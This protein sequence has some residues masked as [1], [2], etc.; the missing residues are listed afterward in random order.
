MGSASAKLRRWSVEL[1]SLRRCWSQISPTLKVV[2]DSSWKVIKMCANA[3][4]YTQRIIL[5]E[6]CFSDCMKLRQWMFDGGPLDSFKR[7]PKVCYNRWGIHV[8]TKHI[9]TL[10]PKHSICFILEKVRYLPYIGLMKWGEVK[11]SDISIKNG[12]RERIESQRLINLYSQKN[13]VTF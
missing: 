8:P 6:V 11:V 7:C 3:T 10:A 9:L 13:N 5:A 1:T 2:L 12:K 4:S